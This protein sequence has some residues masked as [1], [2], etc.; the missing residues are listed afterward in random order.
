[1]SETTQNGRNS[2]SVSN[3]LA[4]DGDAIDKLA[5]LGA[6]ATGA[7]L[8]TIEAAADGLPDS[9]PVAIIHGQTPHVASVKKLVEEWRE[10]PERRAGIALAGDV[11]SF[12]ELV[13]RHKTEDSVVFARSDWRDA[14]LTAVVDYHKVGRGSED[15]GFGR[16][17]IHYAFPFSDEWKTWL[18][19][20]GKAM[21]QRE[22]AEFMEER[23]PDLTALSEVEGA[24]HA[25]ELQVTLIGAPVQIF[26]LA[27][28]LEIN[29]G[30]KVRQNVKL[31]SGEAKITFEEEHTGKD[32]APLVVPGA[33]AL[34]IPLFYNEE[35]ITI[36][37]RLRY[38]IVGGS[39]IW[40]Y[41]LFRVDRIVAEAVRLAKID[42]ATSTELPV[43]EGAPEMTSA[44]S[45]VG[46]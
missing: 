3:G 15:A 10:R 32:G 24:H 44:G 25:R 45:P 1:M 12:C 9:I 42:V 33:F 8:V 19:H 14:A 38:R 18:Q 20:D 2:Y 36:P 21:D 16:H 40:I 41:K 28:G 30:G 39:I 35:P 17:R 34:S 6:S 46:V 23:M 5:K 43:Y 4:I 31:Q 37:V 13:N 26:E 22:F 7:E 27:R 29:V 11:D